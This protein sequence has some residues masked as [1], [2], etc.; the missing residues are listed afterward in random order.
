MKNLIKVTFFCLLINACVSDFSTTED[1]NLFFSSA[2]QAFENKDY[3]ITIKKLSEFKVR[4]PYSRH[5]LDA[6]LLIADSYYQLNN[7]I[8]AAVS[9]HEF[10][11]L[12]PKASQLDYAIFRTGES[13]WAL[14]PEKVDQEQSYTKQAI[15]EWQKLITKFPQSSYAKKSRALIKDGQERLALSHEFIAAFYCK[16]EIWH[17]CAYRYS[18]LAMDYPQFRSLQKKAYKMAADAFEQL[19]SMKRQDKKHL[20]YR[21]FTDDELLNKAK[22]YRHKADEIKIP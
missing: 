4:F 9:Y 7:F 21:D 5:C 20:Y 16:Q 13:Y 11:I 8:E 10:T 22:E 6:E 12:H 3:E 18:K 14:A 19:V 15:K 2:K 1:P 17:A